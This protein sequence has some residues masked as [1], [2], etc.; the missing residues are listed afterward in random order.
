MY[1]SYFSIVK[2]KISLYMVHILVYYSIE[3]I[4]PHPLRGRTL[5]GDDKGKVNRHRN[6]RS[7][8]RGR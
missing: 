3:I 6:T 4:P 1:L 2:V 8:P 7:P 5:K